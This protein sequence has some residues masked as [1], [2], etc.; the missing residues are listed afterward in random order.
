LYSKTD[1]YIFAICFTTTDEK[2][3]SEVLPKANFDTIIEP[4]AGSA[5]YSL[6]QDNW[7]KNVIL[8]EKDPKVASIWEWLI[9]KATVNEIKICLT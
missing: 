3:N 9:N 5:A 6:Y 8:I 4:F 1:F 7:K 2:S